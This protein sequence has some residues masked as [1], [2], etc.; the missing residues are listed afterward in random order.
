MK[1]IFEAMRK[2]GH[3]GRPGWAMKIGGRI[4]IRLLEAEGVVRF[5]LVVLFNLEDPW[6]WKN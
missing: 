3:F 4:K 1:M 6:V 5:R 2:S